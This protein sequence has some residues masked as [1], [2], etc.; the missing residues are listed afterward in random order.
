MN[1]VKMGFVVTV[2][3]YSKFPEFTL[4]IASTSVPLSQFRSEL[5]LTTTRQIDF[6]ELHLD[7]TPTFGIL[8][9]SLRK[10]EHGVR[11][12]WRMNAD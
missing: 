6:C 1:V 10:R 4:S 5:F 9:I 8:V 2:V 11:G 7:R 12:M 3:F